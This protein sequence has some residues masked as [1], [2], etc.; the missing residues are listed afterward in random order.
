MMEI[1][2]IAVHRLLHGG[3]TFG[4]RQLPADHREL[5]RATC[6]EMPSLS[7][8]SL[9]L[10]TLVLRNIHGS[11]GH[12]I[13]R[14]SSLSR[15][16]IDGTRG[17]KYFDPEGEGGFDSYGSAGGQYDPYEEKTDF[18]DI[19]RN[20]PGEPGI[21]YPTY[22]TLPQTGFT[23]E[24]R[25]RGYYADQVAG[26]QVFHV[27][28]DVLVSSFL[29][30]MGSVF[31]QRLL[32][33]DWW[34]K[35][36]CS[37]SAKYTDV[38]RNSYQQD[39]DEMI[40]NAYAMIS[41]QS[42]T[43]VTKDGLV[44]PDRTGS[45]LGYQQGTRRILD[46][47]AMFTAGND[48]RS[49]AQDYPSR[50]SLLAY[51]FQGRRTYQQQDFYPGEKSQPRR[52]QR[53]PTLQKIPDF[54]AY[55]LDDQ[56]KSPRFQISG[57]H[58]TLKELKNH[59]QP[60][61]APTVPT[62]TTT[63]RRFYSP[64][65]PTTF[66]PS[67]FAYNN[68]DQLTDSS[69]YFFVTPPTSAFN[70]GASKESQ[71]NPPIVP[72]HPPRIHELQYHPDYDY[73]GKNAADSGQSGGRFGTRVGLDFQPNRTRIQGEPSPLFRQSYRPF[74]DG[75]GIGGRE[76]D[77][78]FEESAEDIETKDSVGLVHALRQPFNHSRNLL[79]ISDKEARGE[80][81][82]AV[83]KDSSQ[84]DSLIHAGSQHT[85]PRPESTVS[86]EEKEEDQG[87]TE[88]YQAA[89][90]T[91]AFLA[92]TIPPLDE[93]TIEE[94]SIGINSSRSSA[95]LN[96]EGSEEKYPSIDTRLREP[97][98]FFKAPKFQIKVPDVPPVPSLLIRY[99]TLNTQPDSDTRTTESPRF[100][101]TD[102]EDYVN[103][104][105]S[106]DAK[107]SAIGNYASREPPKGFTPEEYRTTATKPL[108]SSTGSWSSSSSP[109]PYLSE[110]LLSRDRSNSSNHLNPSNA[111]IP[112]TIKP[113]TLSPSSSYFPKCGTV[114]DASG[115]T[116]VS[117]LAKTNDL[118]CPE[119]PLR[120][121][122]E[123]SSETSSVMPEKIATDEGI[124]TE[125]PT[126]DDFFR[127]IGPETL[128]E[129][130][131]S[132]ERN[133]SPYKVTLTLD[134]DE[135]LTP[136]GGDSIGKLIARQ[137]KQSSTLNK[138]EIVKSVEAEVPGRSES[139]LQDAVNVL[140]HL[141]SGGNVTGVTESEDSKNQNFNTLSLLQLMSELL[142]MDRAP[143][144]FALTHHRESFPAETI[145]KH[146]NS[147]I[148]LEEGSST[149]VRPWGQSSTDS[150]S[151]ASLSK[152]QILDR[153]TENFGEPLRRTDERLDSR[154]AEAEGCLD[155]H[156][157]LPSSESSS[158]CQNSRGIESTLPTTMSSEPSTRTR[159]TTPTPKSILTTESAKTV[160]KTEFLPSIGFSFDTDRDRKEYV[161]AV[162][163]GLI[164]PQPEESR[165]IEDSERPDS[166]PS[167]QSAFSNKG[168]SGRAQDTNG[169]RGH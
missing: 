51:E 18:S 88:Q 21:D 76:E 78:Q 2:G 123:R 36:D 127:S 58:P 38:N 168:I 159:T 169:H 104:P 145:A 45:L 54:R 131:E 19:R 141:N 47:A 95:D 17:R 73:A 122:T 105:T 130:E 57:K 119:A 153:L 108:I 102:S 111:S 90:D 133:N 147:G 77:L 134:R 137:G 113:T 94:S 49:N 69:D 9:C 46:Y 74:N 86:F 15:R 149:T 164:E 41:L 142:K 5:A 99:S 110:Q 6:C 158:R 8:H 37:S 124:L 148:D 56:G 126:T 60:S 44:D 67:T 4:A 14:K 109:S 81:P 29:C 132:I 40:R 103:Q 62:V 25:S 71:S 26:C 155:S 89:D 96:V 28:H 65:V 138:L 146:V 120:P 100:R 52:L 87:T 101:A 154:L 33:C 157:G 98:G 24:G 139:S 68:L 3:R 23:C 115:G 167:E 31:S 91:D 118:Q 34:T 117:L 72:Y 83:P 64:T 53:P 143:R 42:G 97:M 48:L 66:R 7:I 1:V 165:K 63:T 43:D 160:V 162:L 150:A 32:T 30:P 70:S 152:E 140:D 61:Y 75:T 55:D 85:L 93:T 13:T 116:P 166:E 10:V 151:K 128:K 20:V 11:V 144:P 82:S 106:G 16:A 161:Q 112:S 27:C 107:P 129:I 80:I 84:T 22:T 135:E 92:S 39:D 121:T 59:F 79:T 35:V 163:E 12:E 114:T 125:P 50:D 136:D 156:T